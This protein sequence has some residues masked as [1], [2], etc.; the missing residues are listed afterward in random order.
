[1][2]YSGGDRDMPVKSGGA[3]IFRLT[4]QASSRQRIDSLAAMLHAPN[5]T[6]LV[7][8]DTVRRGESLNVEAGRSEITLQVPALYLNP[9][10]Y[11]V[12]LSMTA[13]GR[14]VV[15]DELDHAFELWVDE[16]GPRGYGATPQNDGFVPCH[17][18]VTLKSHGAEP[19][20]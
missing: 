8:V 17:A 13:G 18:S 11:P 20:R 14:R 7:N 2:E 12:R 5:G 19:V 3:L 9:G 6:R 10:L 16:G 1:V 4:V 15:F